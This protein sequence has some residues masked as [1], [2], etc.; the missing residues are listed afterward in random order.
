MKNSKIRVPICPICGKEEYYYSRCVKCDSR[1]ILKLIEREKKNVSGNYRIIR[2]ISTNT[3]AEIILED[4]DTKEQY[5]ISL[6]QF[7]KMIKGLEYHNL[8]LRERKQGM[9]YGWEILDEQI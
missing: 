4:I 7:F 5:N 3:N 1:P 9:A 2:Y 6:N 8:Q